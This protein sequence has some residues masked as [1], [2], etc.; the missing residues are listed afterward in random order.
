MDEF[1]FGPSW[2]CH[3]GVIRPWLFPLTLNGKNGVTIFSQ[4]LWI[5]SSLKL[6]VTRTGIKSRTSSNFGHIW[7]I[8]LELCALELWKN[9]I[10]SFS[11]SPL[12][13]SLSK[14]KVMR[15]VIKAWMSLKLGQIGLFALELFALERGNF[16]QRPIMEKIMS[17]LFLLLWIQS[18]STLQ[19]T[20]TGITSWMGSNSGRIWTVTLELH[21]L[22]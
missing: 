5:Q 17:P 21:A 20:R 18:S 19:I 8:I 7:P 4:L 1:E 9:D 22:E 2:T 12:I 3:Y 13:G 6:Q 14:F 11:Q 15:T 16:S 10:S